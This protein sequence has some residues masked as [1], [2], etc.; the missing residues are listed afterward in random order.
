MRVIVA[1]AVLV[2]AVNVNALTVST[3]IQKQKEF[4]MEGI[5]KLISGGVNAIG[6]LIHGTKMDNILRDK[7]GLSNETLNNYAEI[8]SGIESSGGKNLENPDS[9]A[10]GIYQFTDE[11]FKTAVQR[12]KNVYEA[13][14][15]TIP[16]WLQKAEEVGVKGLTPDQQK[17]LFLGNLQQQV[18]KKDND[19]NETRSTTELLKAFEDGDK[20]AGYNLFAINHHTNPDKDTKDRGYKFFDIE[21]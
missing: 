15:Y 20:E 18:T 6:D 17:D 12:A 7:Y 4:G 21:S 8:V 11:G 3:T 13:E 10:K 5:K 14:G 2:W 16:L 19:L 1:M 9:S